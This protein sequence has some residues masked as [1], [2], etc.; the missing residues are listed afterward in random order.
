MKRLFSVLFLMIFILFP[1]QE[2]IIDTVYVFDKQIESVKNTQLVKNISLADV[3]KNATNLSEVL[4]FQTPIYIKENG[5]GMVSSPSFRGTTAQQTAFVWNGIELNSMFLGQGDINNLSLLSYDDIDIKAGGGSVIYGSGAIGGSIHLNNHLSYRKGLNARLFLE[6]GS[7]NTFNS[8]LKT[9]YSNGKFNFSV[10]VNHSKSE[11]EYEVPQKKYINRNGQYQNIGV[12]LGAGYK[13][14]RHHRISLFSHWDNGEQH[15]P[16]FEVTQTKTKYKTNNQRFLS[17]WDFKNEKIKNTFN[18]GYLQEGFDYF[19]DIEKPRASGGVG[20]S[21]LIKNNIDFQWHPFIRWSVLA[22]FKMQKGKGY[23]SGIENP[24]MNTGFLA[25]LWKYQPSKKW[26]IDVGVRK[27][28]N[29]RENAPFLYSLSAKYQPKKWYQLLFNFSKNYRMPSFNDLYWNP[30]GNLNLKSET[31]HQWNIDHILK[32]KKI[33][34]NLSGY[35]IN[36]RDM[37]RWLPSD[38]GYWSPIN[39]HRVRSYG[40]ETSLVWRQKW[41]KWKMNANVNYA[42]THSINLATKKNL[43]YVPKHKIN[44][45]AELTYKIFSLYCQSLYNGLVFTDTNE[46]IKKA[47]PSYWVTNM[48][49]NVKINRRI[50]MGVKVNNLTNSIY[51]TKAYFPLPLRHYAL[52]LMIKRL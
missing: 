3:Q 12:N 49:L 39:T 46:N 16:I 45:G 26:N 15:F 22:Q 17:A 50:S 37:I 33:R 34:F 10:A 32:Y 48:G 20:Q 9:H 36:I 51:E 23:Q 8:A 29:E 21:F 43:S 1:A 52:N 14:N 42:Y 41:Q 44:L 40:I 2:K 31:A 6:S 11:N 38:A 35:Y 28:L 4:R 19:S 5:R 18:I 27:E 7:F 47:I 25:T 13:I 24:K 30:G